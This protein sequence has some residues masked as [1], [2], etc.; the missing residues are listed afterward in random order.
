MVF[1][2][3]DYAVIAQA[4]LMSKK[5]LVINGPNLGR[6]GKRE[7][8]IYGKTTLAELEKELVDKGQSTGVEV[9]CFQ[10]NHEGEIIDRLERAVDEGVN[11]CI[12]NAAGLTHTSVALMDSIKSC[13]IP[14]VEVHISQIYQREEFRQHSITG[15]ACTAV[16]SGMGTS[17]Y[18]YALDYL[19]NR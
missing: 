1:G 16:I 15:K 8:S 6:L 18:F 2:V 3:E 4:L 10:S 9:M 13:D 5:I 19:A 7:P 17:G 11:G 14:T 12:L